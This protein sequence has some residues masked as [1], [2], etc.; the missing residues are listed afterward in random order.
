MS[1]EQSPEALGIS[2]DD[3]SLTV[4]LEREDSEILYAFA[5]P[6]GMPCREDSFDAAGGKY[7]MTKD[8]TI[9]NGPFALS[10]WVKS[11]GEETAKFINNKYYSGPRATNLGGVYI[12]LKK[13]DGAGSTA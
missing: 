5:G 11:Q 4:Y 9:S 6:A 3:G 10:R 13:A 12:P 7:C 8:T 1:S 2:Y